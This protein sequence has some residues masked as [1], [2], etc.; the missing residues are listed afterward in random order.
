MNDITTAKENAQ[1]AIELLKK[2]VLTV[3]AEA[4]ES[5]DGITRAGIRDRLGIGKKYYPT[6]ED[7]SWDT[8]QLVYTVLLLLKEDELAEK[9]SPNSQKWVYRIE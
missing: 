6:P 9:S 7:I 4:T 5:G 3:L 1:T 8:G 2:A